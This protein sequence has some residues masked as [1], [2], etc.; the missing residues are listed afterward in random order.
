MSK[1]DTEHLKPHQFGNGKVDAAEMARRSHEARRRKAEE[2]AKAPRDAIAM[3][4]HKRIDLVERATEKALEDACSEDAKLRISGGQRWMRLM[5][6]GFGTVERRTADDAT[7]PEG[8]LPSSR[9]ERMAL[10]ARL[11]AMS[12]D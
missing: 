9:E 6:Q 12:E 3:V 10:L 5:D 1:V 7:T 11:D 4:M 8:A 2:R